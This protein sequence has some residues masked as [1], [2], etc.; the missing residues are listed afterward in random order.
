[1][2]EI[3]AYQNDDGTY[4]VEVL[5]IQVVEK[6]LGKGVIRDTIESKIEMPRAQIS[7]VNLLPGDDEE[8]YFTLKIE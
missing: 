4:R 2:K 1:M 3:H 6:M 8:E 5:G 7:I